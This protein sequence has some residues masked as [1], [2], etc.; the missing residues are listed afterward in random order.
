MVMD[1][2]YG[3]Y[4]FVT[5][6]PNYGNYYLEKDEIV[7]QGKTV[8]IRRFY[9]IEKLDTFLHA[10]EHTISRRRYYWGNLKHI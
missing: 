3:I 7:Y 4:D 9:Y 2:G 1:L 10:A 5:E 6:I 8:I